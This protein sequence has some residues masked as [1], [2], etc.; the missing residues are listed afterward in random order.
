MLT[1]KDGVITSCYIDSVQAKGNFD[2][3]GTITTDLSAPIQTKYQLGENYG[4]VAGGGAIAEW[5]AQ[6]KAVADYAVG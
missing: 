6:V 2:T 1:R 3:T 5:D 4:M